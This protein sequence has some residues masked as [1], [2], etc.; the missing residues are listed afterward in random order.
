[1][2]LPLLASELPLPRHRLV[3]IFPAA[4]EALLASR[5]DIAREPI[6]L[7]WARRSW[8]LIVRRPLPAE[9]G[10]LALGL[11]LP[12]SAGKRR[13]AVAVS[14]DDIASLSAL[15]TLCD[16]VS[17]APE[18]WLPCL[19]ELAALAERYEMQTGI[20]GSLGWQWLTGLNYLGPESDVDI[21]WT[22]NSPDLVEAFLVDLAGLDA[23]AP[24]R[25]DGEL[26]LRSG[27]GVNWREL[28]SKSHHVA[29]K[30][31]A[32]VELHYR[33]SFVGALS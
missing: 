22:P 30:T 29:V 12:P 9:V 7:E 28:Y 26:L 3:R 20:F 21:T 10:G 27:D 2:N 31:A 4:W 18:P 13:I 33:E 23:R 1:M 8:P 16:V 32:D 11:P 24:M 19:R 6:V 5:A 15:P 25:L 17:A 14:P